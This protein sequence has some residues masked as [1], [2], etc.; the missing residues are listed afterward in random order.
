MIT[1]LVDGPLENLRG[2]RSCND[3][4][5]SP[6]DG[7]NKALFQNR[8]CPRCAEATEVTIRDGDDVTLYLKD[9]VLLRADVGGTTYILN[10]REIREL[11]P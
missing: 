8:H 5:Y 1:I 2:W 11:F 6:W 4:L 10:Y 7:H 3:P 9:G